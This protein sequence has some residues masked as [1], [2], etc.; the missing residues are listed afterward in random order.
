MIKDELNRADVHADNIGVVG[1][2]TSIEGGIHFHRETIIY[3]GVKPVSAGHL[4]DACQAQV[5]SVLFD[6]RFKY[7][8]N[9]YVNRAVEQ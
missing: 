5:A 2:Y 1:D 4:L 3:D 7:D 9:L 6:A 8:A